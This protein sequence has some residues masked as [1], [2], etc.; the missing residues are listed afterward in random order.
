MF[1]ISTSV[2]EGVGVSFPV[3]ADV[4]REL[5]PGGLLLWVSEGGDLED[6]TGSCMC[7]VNGGERVRIGI[8]IGEAAV[9]RGQGFVES[10]RGAIPRS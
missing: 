9:G 5:C 6:M 7:I 10:N 8:G 1:F 2:F 4:D 3:M